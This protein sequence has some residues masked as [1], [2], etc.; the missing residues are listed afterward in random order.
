MSKS[1]AAIDKRIAE[2][3]LGKVGRAERDLKK[4][5]FKTG[6]IESVKLIRGTFDNPEK[7]LSIQYQVKSHK[8]SFEKNNQ[9]IDKLRKYLRSKLFPDET[10]LGYSL[11]ITDVQRQELNHEAGVYKES[12]IIRQGIEIPNE[13]EFRHEFLTDL[14]NSIENY[15]RQN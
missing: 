11:Q 14:K 13:D 4:V 12:L 6:L 10:S 8:G 9:E 5:L 15:I 2:K 1:Q 3:R 7:P